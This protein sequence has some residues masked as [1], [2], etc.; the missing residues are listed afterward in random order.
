MKKRLVH[1]L[2][3]NTLQ[4]IINQGFGVLI[5]YVLSVSIDK[6]SFGQ[7]N[8][9]LAVLLSAFNILSCGVD[10]VIIKKVAQGDDAGSLLSLYLFHVIITGLSF[11]SLLLLG[12]LFFPGDSNMYNLMLLI[13]VG[14]LL[15]FLATPLKQVTSGMEQF[16][17]LAYMLVVSNIVRGLALAIFALLHLVDLNTV[18]WIFITG[19]GLEL[20]VCIV[21]FKR[22]IKLPVARAR[23]TAGYKNLLMESLPQV[24]VVLITSALAR[25][26]WLFIGFM[27]SAV[28][29]AEYSFAYKIFEISSLPL[30]A[31]A[32]LLIPRFTKLFKSSDHREADLKLLVRVEII[33]AVFTG[34][35]LTICWNPLIDTVT[36]GKYG[37]V[38]T[39]T[40]FILSLC[41]PL[42]YLNNFFWTV[43][44]VQ[45]RSKMI[46]RSFLIAL[47]VNIAGDLILI[48]LYQNEGAAIAFLIA[49]V[50]QFGY[51]FSKNT[52]PGLINAVYNLTCCTAC[53][54]AV[55]FTV[56]NYLSNTWLSAFS[57]II[58]YV[59]LLLATRQ[60]RLDDGRKLVAIL[61]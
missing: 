20:L 34:L 10:Q 22:Y 49:C 7:L 4:L 32:P 60:V 55:G 9:A 25:F 11:Y 21:L 58:L 27:V 8:L 47:T 59:I 29:L 19:D 18:T 12:K 16:K 37:A 44:F 50:V 56:K 3:A 41:L 42:V 48:P 46:L 43:Y 15:L 53:A 24:G 45:N 6:N 28:K 51:Y 40:I 14:K 35:M 54:L 1:N 13:G 36:H 23:S 17:I 57:A 5:F 30:L 52:I 26:D 33:I 31:I 39:T 61:S 38:N 2:S